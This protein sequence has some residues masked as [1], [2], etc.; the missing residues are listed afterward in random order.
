MAFKYSVWKILHL[1]S[2]MCF[3]SS[4][5]WFQLFPG[6]HIVVQLLIRVSHYLQVFSIISKHGHHEDEILSTLISPFFDLNFITLTTHFRLKGPRSIPCSKL[7][8]HYTTH[9][10]SVYLC[11]CGSRNYLYLLDCAI[12]TAE[13]CCKHLSSQYGYVS[14]HLPLRSVYSGGFFSVCFCLYLQGMSVLSEAVIMFIRASMASCPFPGT[15]SHTWIH[16]HTHTLDKNISILWYWVFIL[17]CVQITLFFLLFMNL[18]G[19]FLYV[20]GI[21]RYNA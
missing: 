2:N 5:L 16:L 13:P 8:G 10:L 3:K 19:K 14:T 12:I 17:Y 20:I 11:V 21:V 4:F 7:S 6:M 18:N 9:K 15:D 1:F